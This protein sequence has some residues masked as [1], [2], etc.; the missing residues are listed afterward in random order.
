MFHKASQAPLLLLSVFSLSIF[1]Q[2]FVVD[3]SFAPVLNNQVRTVK[4]L[5]DGK[6]LIAGDFTTINGV[7]RKAVARLNADGTLDPSFDAS[8]VLGQFSQSYRVDG[9]LVLPDGRVLVFG[10]LPYDGGSGPGRV[11]RLNTD[12]SPDATLTSVPNI[13]PNGGFGSIRRVAVLASGKILVCGDFTLP[14]NNPKAH[15]ARYNAN[16]TYDAAFPTIIDNQCND[17][18]AQP[19]GKY[20]VAGR[21]ST[22]NGASSLRLVRFNADDSID[23]TFNPQPS[24]PA[25][26]T[27]FN[28]IFL[29]PDGRIVLTCSSGSS[30]SIERLNSD[31]SFDSTFPSYVG[32]LGEALFQSNGKLIAA[33]RSVINRYNRDKT[34]DPSMGWATFNGTSNSPKSASLA[35]DGGLIVGGDFV[36]I[37]SNTSTATRRYLARFTAQEIPI[38]RKFDFDGDGRDDI[39]VFRPSDSIWY[40]N[41][42]TAGFGAAQFGISTD[43]PVA[44]DYD[45]DGKTDIAVFR[46]GVWYWLQSSDNVFAYRAGAQG[47]D[48]PQPGG[49]DTENLVFFRP[50]DGKFYLRYMWS[51][52]GLNTLPMG[53]LALQASDKPMVADYDGDGLDDVAAFRDGH[54]FVC[55]GGSGQ[56]R[57]YQFG[58]AGDI[59]VVGDFDGDLRADYAVFRPSDGTWYINRTHE[60]FYALKWG[61][62]GDL[63]VPADYDGDGK[64]DIAVFRDGVWYQ[65]RSGGA[66]HI[67]QFGLAGDIPI[68]LR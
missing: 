43:K 21:F 10:M 59:P 45:N 12:G 40:L 33:G 53:T 8:W 54:W 16:G 55:I 36:S 14:N 52:G 26:S 41:R 60:G 37:S 2:K 31:G 38:K 15:L 51:W 13:N 9:A 65:W 28:K 11:L 7:T 6:I 61:L 39:S 25:S 19:D 17:I 20:I 30:G 5:G 64:T 56:T 22:V 34:H 62:S 68:Q 58:M 48:I 66:I 46:D 42:S 3:Q 35:A 4:V 29:Q 27:F 23:T 50:S 18:A 67:E 57:H 63:P 24:T 32:D 49:T 44:A 1:A 47:S